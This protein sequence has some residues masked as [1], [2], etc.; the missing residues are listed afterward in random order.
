MAQGTVEWFN[1]DKGYGFIAP[2]TAVPTSSF[3]TPPYK[4]R[5]TAASRRISES[6]SPRH[7]GPRDLRAEQG[8][9]ALAR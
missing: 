5:V 7:V 8:S 1:A 3:T 2:K 4:P 6:T 9:A